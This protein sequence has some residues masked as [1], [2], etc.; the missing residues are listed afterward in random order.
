[1]G[2]CTKAFY[3]TVA[4][5]GLR[6]VRLR[7]GPKG[8]IRT[9]RAWIDEW[10][11]A[12]AVA[13]QIERDAELGEYGP[14]VVK[15]FMKNVSAWRPFFIERPVGWTAGTRKRMDRIFTEA[16]AAIQK[17]NDRYTNPSGTVDIEKHEA[18]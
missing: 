4:T 17:L 7:G 3:M 9:T 2:V 15:A 12:K 5:E 14:S 16:D 18:A 1:M 10:I 11:E 13:K 8:Q 6:H